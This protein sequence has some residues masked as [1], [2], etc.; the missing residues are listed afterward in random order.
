PD[1]QVKAQFWTAESYGDPEELQAL[2]LT[3]T[4]EVL[5][6]GIPKQF[7]TDF[8]GDY[9]PT[10]KNFLNWHPGD[11]RVDIN[12]PELLY[13]YLYDEAATGLL[14]RVTVTYSDKSSHTVDKFTLSDVTAGSIY[15]MPVGYTQL[16][17]GAINGAKTPVKYTVWME[18]HNF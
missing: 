11:K 13:F 12:Q 10:H 9:I 16:D 8:F 6:G 5:N 17:I 1:N 15:R 7:A 18:D 3:E 14:L 4:F 2:T